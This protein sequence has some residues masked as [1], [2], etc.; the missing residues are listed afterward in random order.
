MPSDSKLPAT[1]WTRSTS[2]MSD[3][4]VVV[5]NKSPSLL[6][7]STGSSLLERMENFR[8]HGVFETS[9]TFSSKKLREGCTSLITTSADI[10]TVRSSFLAIVYHLEVT[11]K[12]QMPCGSCQILRLKIRLW[13]LSVRDLFSLAVSSDLWKNRKGKT[14][15]KSSES[16]LEIL[17]SAAPQTML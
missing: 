5:I 11:S 16:A 2:R 1:A 17:F 8:L 12:F 9:M 6:H 3:D 10:R 14:S 15:S 13:S 4:L 7:V